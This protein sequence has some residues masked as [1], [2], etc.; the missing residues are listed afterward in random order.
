ML[1]EQRALNTRFLQRLLIAIALFSAVAMVVG[2]VTGN[3][4][5][6]SAAAAS[7]A[8][9]VTVVAVA[10]NFDLW[11]PRA[12]NPATGGEREAASSLATNAGLS[13]IAYGW[14]AIAMQGLYLTP[15]TG[16]KW[17]HGWQYA[18]AMALLSLGSGLFARTIAR[19]VAGADPDGW[20]THLRSARPL[21]A[22]QALVAGCGLAVLALSGKLASVRADWAANRVF[23]AL[24]VAILAIAMVSLV[25]L[26]RTRKGAQ[27]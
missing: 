6:V 10:A 2:G 8:L 17:Q 15:L 13:A 11:R 12:S 26:A 23:S 20:R 3:G 25:S 19:P 4:L 24:A 7:F 22:V 5:V 14:G 27:G 16:L 9:A 1:R 18:L 21:A